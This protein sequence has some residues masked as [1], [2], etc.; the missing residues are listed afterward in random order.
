MCAAM[1]AAVDA[2]IETQAYAA[3]KGLGLTFS[4]ESVRAVGLSIY[5]SS[6]K[7]GR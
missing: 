2:V 6:C 1:M 4:E 5:I 7:G 3:R